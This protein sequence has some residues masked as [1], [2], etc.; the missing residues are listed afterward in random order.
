MKAPLRNIFSD[1][2]II[3]WSPQLLSVLLIVFGLST[4]LILGMFFPPGPPNTVNFL[5]VGTH[6]V[7]LFV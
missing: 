4:R 7:K 5:Q 1:G 6:V 3:S 2:S